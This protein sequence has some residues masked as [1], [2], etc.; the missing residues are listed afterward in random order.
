MS[1]DH[2]FRIT[3]DNDLRFYRIKSLHN[4]FVDKIVDNFTF[5]IELKYDQANDNGAKFITNAFPF[6]LT[7]NSKYVGGYEMFSN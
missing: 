5:I 4:L 2:K 7:K 6:R 1:S 3:V